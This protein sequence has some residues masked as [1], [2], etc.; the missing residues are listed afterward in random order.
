MKRCQTCISI[1][2]ESFIACIF[3][4]AHR[5]LHLHVY[6]DRTYASDIQIQACDGHKYFAGLFTEIVQ[7]LDWNSYIIK[8]VFFHLESLEIW[9]IGEKSGQNGATPW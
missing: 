5:D 8:K 2:F 1:F 4:A 6:T 3:L 9:D 7:Y